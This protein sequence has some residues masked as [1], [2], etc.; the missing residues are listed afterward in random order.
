MVLASC[1]DTTRED[2]PPEATSG[3]GT[4][5][6]SADTDPETT[7]STDDSAAE[8][9]GGI[10]DSGGSDSS[11][12]S[13]S[14]GPPSS[15]PCDGADILCDGF[16]D[17]GGLDPQWAY[18]GNPANMPTLDE[19]RAFS[20]SRSLTFPNTDTQGAFVY[21]T[22]GLPTA[23][24]RVYVRAYVSFERDTAQM[25]GHVSYIV[26]ADAPSNGA[27]MRLGASQN[28][29]NGQMMVDVNLLGSGPEYTQFS[30][31]DVT[32]GAPS[33]ARGV[34][35]QASTWYCMEALFDGAGDEFR[36]WIDD[37]EIAAMHVTDWAQGVSGWSPQYSVVKIGGQNYSGSL[38]Q[39]W[40]DDVAIGS[41]RLGCP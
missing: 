24:N 29:G 35:L 1:A 14:G 25:G 10:A 34:G 30:N 17:G 37:T 19:G 6:S 38:G 8:S 32:G 36:L 39:V 18:V 7:D 21:P 4:L 33:G 26:G 28:F 2:N 9:S 23:D 27:E 12:E 15:D 20:G 22:S 13:S 40:F 5:T 3:I 11:D 31:G 16:E 41:T